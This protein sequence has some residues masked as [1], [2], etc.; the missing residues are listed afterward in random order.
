[1]I[2]A[3]PE[4]RQTRCTRYR[5][6]YS[7]C[8][9][10]ADACP[11]DAIALADDGARADSA[12]CRNCGLCSSA[13]RTGAWNAGNLPRVELLKQAIR[14]PR[15]SFACAPSGAAGDAIVPCL[16]ALDAATLAYLGRRGIAV[17]LRGAAHCGVCEHGSR[18][19]AQ[20]DANLDAVAMLRAAADEA[21]AEL[22]LSNEPAR[23][24]SPGG[25]FASAKRQLFRRLFGRPSTA[26]QAAPT[27]AEPV[28]DQAIRA[29][30]PFVTEPRELLQ[31][32]AKKADGGF[33]VREHEALPLMKL[34][35]TQGCTACEACFRA[36][37]SGALQVRES[38]T[39]WSLAFDL[40]R[41]VGCEVCVEV[42]KPRVLQPAAEFD[43]A[44]GGGDAVLHALVKQRCAR[45]D[46]AFVSAAPA[47]TCAVCADDETA[48]DAI[49]G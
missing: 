2:T 33:V 21:W 7:E 4:F 48:F 31:I 36:C 47:Q 27:A 14:A 39:A 41:C 18:G 23:R 3:N 19:A 17:E 29:A 40:D 44:P 25:E 45:C 32:I 42:C 26:A 1:L 15:W 30:R 49:F 12:K 10:C 6:R 28:P 11:H 8:R 13:C 24:R 16:G 5:Y 35:L 46:R 22:T 20:I 38:D 37:P 34:A 43:I 9:R